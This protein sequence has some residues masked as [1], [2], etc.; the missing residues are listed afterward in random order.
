MTKFCK[1]CFYCAEP[2]NRESECR[3]PKSKRQTEWKRNN[4]VTGEEYGKDKYEY[5]SCKTMRDASYG[6]VGYC[7]SKAYLFTS[8]DDMTEEAL[9]AKSKSLMERIKALIAALN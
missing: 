1:D 6:E 7:G 8:P 9:A 2:T 4:I 5:Y 3:H